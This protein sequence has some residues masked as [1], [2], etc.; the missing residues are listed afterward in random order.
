MARTKRWEAGT[1]NAGLAIE[2]LRTRNV[3]RLLGWV[4]EE[5]IDPVE[6]PVEEFCARLGM[7]PR[8]L[9]APLHFLLFAG[10]Q[11]HPAGGLRDLVGTFDCPEKAWAAFR[12]LRQ[13]HTSAPGWAQLAT[14]DSL[15]KV[16]Q[17]AW[18]G[19]A[20]GTDAD[21]G[22]GDGQAPENA[23]ARVAGGR[24]LRRIVAPETGYL[25]AVTPS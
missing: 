5:V 4:R 19:V 16:R 11:P 8:C 15:G 3:V 22:R 24:P 6:I 12:E 13:A 25:R 23:Q 9:G 2:Y 21:A 10:P 20:P 14:I 17:L 18:Y 7:D 1:R